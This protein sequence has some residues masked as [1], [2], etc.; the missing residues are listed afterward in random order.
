MIRLVDECILEK[1]CEKTGEINLEE[2]VPVPLFDRMAKIAAIVLFL[3]LSCL[4]A[5][6]DIDEFKI[7]IRPL[8]DKFCFD[9]HSTEKQGGVR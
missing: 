1:L 5:N 6:D 9:C 8:L 2:F 4:A 7:E 3:S